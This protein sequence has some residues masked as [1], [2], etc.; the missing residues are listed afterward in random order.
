MSGSLSLKSTSDW[1]PFLAAFVL[2]LAAAVLLSLVATPNRVVSMNQT[3][4]WVRALD[5]F[6]AAVVAG[7][8]IAAYFRWPS[9]R[10][11]LP[12]LVEVESF[13]TLRTR[14]GLTG[15]GFAALLESY[16]R[17]TTGP[18]PVSFV[19]SPPPAGDDIE[20]KGVKIPIRALRAVWRTLEA[21]KMFK[22]RG[23]VDNVSGNEL[24]RVD[25]NGTAFLSVP[26][27]AGSAGV[28]LALWEIA[29]QITRVIDPIRLAHWYW[30]ENNYIPA[31]QLYREYIAKA[32]PA[33][34]VEF[35]LAQVELA[36][37][38]SDS[39]L[40]RLEHLR[41]TELPDAQ[42]KSF[43]ILKASIH[44][45]RGE[46]EECERLAYDEL[47]RSPTGEQAGASYSLLG[48]ISMCRRDYATAERQ[49]LFARDVLVEELCRRLSI[50]D[51][52]QVTWQQLQDELGTASE[53]K[54]ELFN[55]VWSLCDSY[56][57]RGLCLQRLEQS[58][59]DEF[60]L[61]LEAVRAMNLVGLGNIRPGTPR[62]L[63]ARIH[64]AY[65]STVVDHAQRQHILRAALEWEKDAIKWFEIERQR[66]PRD[67]G[68]LTRLAWSY[69]GTFQCLTR[70]GDSAGDEAVQQRD[71]ALRACI[72]TLALINQAERHYE[73]EL[74]FAHACV[75]AE[76]SNVVAATDYLRVAVEKTRSS[77]TGFSSALNRARLDEDLDSIRSEQAFLD[78]VYPTPGNDSGP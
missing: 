16:L 6:L 35:A 48:R 47:S 3:A 14:K 20:I 38:R 30:V 33:A 51:W 50:S 39:A 11:R 7:L 62:Q 23:F 10:R 55:I 69:F 29:R 70:L 28:D 56:L 13:Q 71:E 25:L 78:L 77:G 26:V 59:E 31:I 9:R 40:A 36:S 1:K 17:G 49:W 42:R 57:S 58:T 64:R 19:F 68:V 2:L 72:D 5:G 44:F 12:L 8:G 46:Y 66:Q 52:E 43:R 63:G 73:A 34:D 65:A 54:Y 76:R 27:P 15:S 18:S 75:A 37:D 53:N 24:I 32:G 22:I 60:W 41:L 21:R 61:A 4:R 45:S 74:A 67:V